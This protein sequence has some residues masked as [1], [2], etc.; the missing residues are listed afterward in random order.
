MHLFFGNNPNFKISWKLSYPSSMY[1][2]DVTYVYFTTINKQ[3]PLVEQMLGWGV[4]DNGESWRN[5]KS[6]DENQTLHLQPLPITRF[7]SLE[8]SVS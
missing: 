6:Q 5:L 4:I 7:G 3:V 8:A 2:G 1:S